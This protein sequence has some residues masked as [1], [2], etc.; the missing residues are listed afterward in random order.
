MDGEEKLSPPPRERG[1][2][3]EDLFRLLFE[4][5]IFILERTSLLR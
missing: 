4:I 2:E 3:E 5:W 1:P